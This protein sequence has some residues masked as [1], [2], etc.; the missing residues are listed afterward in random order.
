MAKEFIVYSASKASFEAQL[1]SGDVDSTQIGIIAE[2]GEIW[3]NGAYYPII[4][5]DKFGVNTY[6]PEFTLSDLYEQRE[7][8]V[9]EQDLRQA[10]GDGKL[11]LLRTGIG[12]GYIPVSV[13]V[14]DF[15]YITAVSPYGGDV[16]EVYVAGD[17]LQYES[18]RF[19]P[20]EGG[21]MEQRYWEDHK[22]GVAD[23]LYDEHEGMVYALPNSR[24]QIAGVHDY[25]IATEEYVTNNMP[26]EIA[27][28]TQKIVLSNAPLKNGYQANIV[29]EWKTSPTTLNI[30][31]LVASDDSYDN[32]W[33]IR[34]GATS[35][36]QLNIIPS[37][38]WKDGVRPSFGAWGIC[39]LTFRKDATT[40][41]YLGEWKIYA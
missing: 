11:I 16:F 3:A 15:V 29:Y 4:K 36:T 10:V 31:A 41:T 19:M 32:V 8:D 34:F 28:A 27:T 40:G 21:V 12:F 22:I 7:I 20:K 39:E 30:N 23:G 25:T 18:K 1:A 2:T 37:V 24:A 26:T 9:R 35:S 14:D 6:V 5:S 33:T 13:D 17:K 38:Y